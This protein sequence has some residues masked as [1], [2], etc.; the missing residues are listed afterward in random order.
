MARKSAG[1]KAMRHLMML[2]IMAFGVSIRR[3]N[4]EARSWYKR[5][6]RRITP[7]PSDII[8]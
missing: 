6:T 8:M 3:G 2:K 7:Y 5:N 4:L 1:L